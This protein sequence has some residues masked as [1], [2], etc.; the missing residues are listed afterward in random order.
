MQKICAFSGVKITRCTHDLDAP[1]ILFCS[2]ERGCK[3][4][5]SLPGVDPEEIDIDVEGHRV[6]ASCK[7]RPFEDLE[8]FS[9]TCL[10][11]EGEDE[12]YEENDI[13]D[14]E[15]GR[16][17]RTIPLPMDADM[18]SMTA[19]SINGILLL[20]TGRMVISVKSRRIKVFR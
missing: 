20:T 7:R 8:D 14:I 16:M 18:D 19:G 2:G 17:R 10:E 15:F 6:A 4:L 5:V 12:E 13:P 9:E 1:Q 11:D 3:L